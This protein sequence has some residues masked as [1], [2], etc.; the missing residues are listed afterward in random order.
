M[1][2]RQL[3]VVEW[4]GYQCFTPSISSS[5]S[6]CLSVSVSLSLSLSLSLSFCLSVSVSLFLS[7]SLSLSLFLSLSFCLSVSLSL[8]LSIC[9]SVS[10]CSILVGPVSGSVFV[11]EC[12]RCTL[13]V[14]CQ[15]VCPGQYCCSSIV[16]LL[17][18]NARFGPG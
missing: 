2:Y 16:F 11:D 13:V 14:A 5:L 8:S 15:Q 10:L 18:L 1:F 3:C 4:R 9:L 12:S 6:V 7:L 17:D